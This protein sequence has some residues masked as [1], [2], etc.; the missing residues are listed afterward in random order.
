MHPRW[1]PPL[2]RSIQGLLHCFDCHILHSWQLFRCPGSC[3]AC[4]IAWRPC[5]DTTPRLQ[6]LCVCAGH[7]R[8]SRPCI[9]RARQLLKHRPQVLCRI[10]KGPY[11]SVNHNSRLP[12]LILCPNP[13]VAWRPVAIFSGFFKHKTNSHVSAEVA[14]SVTQSDGFRP[15]HRCVLSTVHRRARH[16]HLQIAGPPECQR[17]RPHNPV[18]VAIN[19]ATDLT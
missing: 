4:A 3:G 2:R 18:S 1:A 10:C 14:G 13:V 16:Q 9:N 11:R 6:C 8:R 19:Q 12:Q 5:R 17:W 15:G 7:K